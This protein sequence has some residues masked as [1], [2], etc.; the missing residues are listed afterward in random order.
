MPAVALRQVQLPISAFG[1][2]L[3]L[4][5]QR[6]ARVEQGRR[7]RREEPHA[8]ESGPAQREPW[9]SKQ[10]QCDPS[11]GGKPHATDWLLR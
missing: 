7:V 2:R 11:L 10:R 5:A 1:H 8:R 9:P 6:G 4:P 3:R